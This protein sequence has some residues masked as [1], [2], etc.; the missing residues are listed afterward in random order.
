MNKPT[1]KQILSTFSVLLLAAVIGTAWVYFHFKNMHDACWKEVMFKASEAKNVSQ[2]LSYEISE[3]Q[4]LIEQSLV[5]RTKILEVLENLR[6]KKDSP[7]SGRDLATLKSGTAY[8][9]ELREKLYEIAQRYECTINVGKL[10][11]KRHSIDPIVHNK[12][13]LLSLSAVNC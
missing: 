13:V 5:A 11:L 9:L 12:A 1:K 4:Q 7:L 6:K 10:Y 8:Y 3:F 2:A